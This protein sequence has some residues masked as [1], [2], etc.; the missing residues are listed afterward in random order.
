MA[1]KKTQAKSTPIP[2]N[3]LSA[4]H[5]AVYER[6]TKMSASQGFKSLVASGIYNNNG[7]LTKRYGG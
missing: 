4:V 3:N 2:Q 6:V 1:N 7:S 5:R